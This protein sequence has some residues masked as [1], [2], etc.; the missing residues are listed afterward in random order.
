MFGFSDKRYKFFSLIAIFKGT[1][2][3]VTRISGVRKH[4]LASNKAGHVNVGVWDELQQL[5]TCVWSS[6]WKWYWSNRTES[7]SDSL[8]K[9]VH[10]VVVV[11]E[12]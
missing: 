8:W 10:N 2:E 12:H 5:D 11:L 7:L 6:A 3:R 9:F 4:I 1:D